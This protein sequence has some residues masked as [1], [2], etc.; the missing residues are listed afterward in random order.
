MA[1]PDANTSDVESS[2]FWSDAARSRISHLP[3]ISCLPSGTI[4]TKLEEV[5]AAQDAIYK[6]KRDL[7]A[8]LDNEKAAFTRAEQEFCDAYAVREEA[9]EAASLALRQRHN[10]LLPV[11]RLPPEILATVFTCLF[12]HEH[13]CWSPALESSLN[14]RL[15]VTHVCR[16][17]RQ[18]ALEHSSLWADID[19]EFSPD[20]VATFLARA[21]SSPL[22]I[23][24]FG[25]SL[26]S[27]QLG[28]LVENVS[29][30]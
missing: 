21:R 7:R 9:L 26:R 20:C 1:A 24:A 5:T 13:T 14:F 27:W 2:Q 12:A 15:P 4:F 11:T 3:S 23:D 30:M 29:R 16:R 18:V 19:L 25:H 17:W 22:F 6:S 28:F 8:Q 10:T